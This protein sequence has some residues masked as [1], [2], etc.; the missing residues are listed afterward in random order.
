MNHKG[1]PNCLGN[2]LV[3]ARMATRYNSKEVPGIHIGKE[4]C[5]K[6]I[7]FLQHLERPMMLNSTV[8]IQWT[9]GITSSSSKINA[10]FSCKRVCL[11]SD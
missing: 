11:Y 8:T 6:G 7:E 1:A 9:K 5:E 3:V 4:P 10:L 2:C